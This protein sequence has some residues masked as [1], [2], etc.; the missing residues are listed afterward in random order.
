M[1]ICMKLVLYCTK[2]DHPTLFKLQTSNSLRLMPTS[3]T[4]SSPYPLN[5]SVMRHPSSV[6]RHRLPLTHSLSLTHSLTHSLSPTATH[7]LQGRDVR[8]S[9]RSIVCSLLLAS[10]GRTALLLACLR[11]LV[12]WC[13]RRRHAAAP[14]PCRA[15]RRAVPCRAVRRAAPRT[16]EGFRQTWSVLTDL[17]TRRTSSRHVTHLVCHVIDHRMQVVASLPLVVVVVVVVDVA[18]F[19]ESWSRHAVMVMVSS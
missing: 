6:I 4:G 8:P 2:K 17:S 15:V 11:W 1:T 9:I 19:M 10:V 7:S 3:F 18:G 13:A 5:Q 12:G 14:P 16:N